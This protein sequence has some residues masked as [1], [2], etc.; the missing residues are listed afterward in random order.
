MQLKRA[1]VGFQC[2]ISIP[3]VNHKTEWQ[4]IRHKLPF[5]MLT[6][7]RLNKMVGIQQASHT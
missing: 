4:V 3:Q 2:D 1:E 7:A 5:C 6:L